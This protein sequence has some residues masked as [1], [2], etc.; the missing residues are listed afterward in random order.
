MPALVTTTA[1]SFN[2]PPHRGVGTTRERHVLAAART[3]AYLT[4]LGT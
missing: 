2:R 4:V 1:P 3:P